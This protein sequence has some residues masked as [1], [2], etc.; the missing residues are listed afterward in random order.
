MLSSFDIFELPFVSKKLVYFFVLHKS[1]N[2]WAWILI[3]SSFF[4]LVDVLSVF[5]YLR[6]RFR[7]HLLF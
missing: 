2:D 5:H 7:A 3:V 4:V 6:D 1:C